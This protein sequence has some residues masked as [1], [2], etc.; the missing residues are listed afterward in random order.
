MQRIFDALQTRLD[1]FVEQR[2]ELALVVGCDPGESFV[3]VKALDGKDKA[4]EEDLY[5]LVPDPFDSAPLYAGNVVQGM[6]ERMEAVRALAEKAERAPDLPP[7]PGVALDPGADP[8][9][10]VRACL[11]YMRE[12]VPVEGGKLVVGLLPTEVHDPHGF[13]SFCLQ[14]LD[15]SPPVPWCHHMRFVVRDDRNEPMLQRHASGLSRASW[16]TFDMGH[17]NVQKALEEEVVDGSL[18]MPRRMQ[19]LF[20]L[21]GYDFSYRRYEDALEKYGVL[22]KWFFGTGDLAHGALVLV[23]IGEVLQYSGHPVKAKEYYLRALAAAARCESAQATINA[24]LRLAYLHY[25]EQA[26]Q[27]AYEYFKGAD[28]LAQATL[29]PHLKMHCLLR[30]GACRYKLEDR[31]GAW[32]QWYGGATFARELKSNDELFTFLGQLKDLFVELGL[33]K[34]QDEAQKEMQELAAQGAQAVPV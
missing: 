18:K 4:S 25:D 15:H 30:A 10:R 8:V 34:E 22:Q 32:E 5:W 31:H 28:K 33:R 27:S 11:T 19:A 9:R 29:N 16:Y 12:R 2:S 7:L 6:F 1:A 20:I 17:D 24:T 21:A 13:A 3:V 14:L 23:G 26:W